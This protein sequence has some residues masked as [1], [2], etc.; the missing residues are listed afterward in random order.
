MQLMVTNF[1]LCVARNQ[2]KSFP[3]QKE[4]LP[5]VIFF[6]LLKHFVCCIVVKLCLF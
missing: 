1:I 5:N 6:V 2:V 4:M 3:A